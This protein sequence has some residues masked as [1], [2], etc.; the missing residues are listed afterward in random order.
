VILDATC[1]E[2]LR[3]CMD[4]GVGL[5][6]GLLRDPV[7]GRTHGVRLYR[8][9]CF[10]RVKIRDSISPDMDFGA[11]IARH[12]WIR[13]HALR[14]QGQSAGEWHTFGDHQP[15]YT[16]HYTFCK[17]LL[18]GVRCRYR[19]HEGRVGRIFQQ[20]RASNHSVATIALIATSHGLFLRE[21]RDLLVPYERTSEFACLETFL[22]EGNGD[23][24]PAA[25]D[26]D[27]TDHDLGALFQRAYQQGIAHRQHG[28]ASTF[29]AQLHTL[30]A[31]G[32]LG[33]WTAAVGMCHGLFHDHY[34]EAAVKEAFASLTGI[35]AE[36]AP[37]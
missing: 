7:V 33:S 23:K 11:D 27:A 15:D 14:H 16:P 31:R 9:E 3:A 37:W 17:F 2:E 28:A 18:E 12:G 25:V 26:T 19:R 5:A 35:L 8:T 13:L 20:L 4:D 24:I 36:G 10:D 22:A 6:S 30:K 1:L 32:G 34:R 29:V 21:R